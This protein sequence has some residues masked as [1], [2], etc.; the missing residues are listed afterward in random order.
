MDAKTGKNYFTFI[1][2]DT[3][4]KDRDGKSTL[5]RLVYIGFEIATTDFNLGWKTNLDGKVVVTMILQ[6]QRKN[7]FPQNEKKRVRI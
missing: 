4:V 7:S 1:I 5:S 2:V 3:P 6:K